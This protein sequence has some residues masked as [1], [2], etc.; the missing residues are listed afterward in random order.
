MA[1]KEPGA[2]PQGGG[3]HRG[4]DLN[5]ITVYCMK[6]NHKTSVK[7]SKFKKRFKNLKNV[8]CLENHSWFNI[9]RI[10]G[11]IKKESERLPKAFK[12]SQGE[13]LIILSMRSPEGSFPKLP[14][15]MF[16]VFHPEAQGLVGEAKHITPGGTSYINMSVFT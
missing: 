14:C 6:K 3:I 7:K 9:K 8:I 16:L 5:T 10:A 4:G 11:K 12:T 15:A 2:I 1:R 13:A